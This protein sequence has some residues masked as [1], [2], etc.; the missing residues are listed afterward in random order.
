MPS[1]TGATVSGNEYRRC[2]GVKLAYPNKS[3]VVQ[4]AIMEEDVQ[5][6]EGRD[7]I[8]GKSEIRCEYNIIDLPAISIPI[9]DANLEPTG[10]TTTL[11]D[12]FALI[13]S[14]YIELAK[15]RDSEGG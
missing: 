1:Y 10:G 4:I 5:E 15:R 3:G 2:K 6:R 7:V 13:R 11:A 14:A 12:I 8:T 9:L